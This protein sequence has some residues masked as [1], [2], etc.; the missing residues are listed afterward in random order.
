MDR[1]GYP[2]DVALGAIETYD[3]IWFIANNDQA[4]FVLW[5]RRVRQLSKSA[6]RFLNPGSHA[7]AGIKNHN[8]GYGLVDGG[9]ISYGLGNLIVQDSEICRVQSS[10][11]SARMIQDRNVHQHQV[12]IGSNGVLCG[13]GWN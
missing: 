12:N 10:N 6:T 9:K 3:Y 8:Q 5:I 11:G 4:K 13:R 1:I 2:F 7:S